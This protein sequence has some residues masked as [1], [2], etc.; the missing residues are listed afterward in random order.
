MSILSSRLKLCKVWRTPCCQLNF[1]T[2]TSSKRPPKKIINGSVRK[3][4][5]NELTLF[6]AAEI[7][8]FHIIGNRQIKKMHAV[9]LPQILLNFS[10]VGV[11]LLDYYYYSAVPVAAVVSLMCHPIIIW[12]GSSKIVDLSF[13]PTKNEVY[14]HSV[15]QVNHT[16]PITHCSLTS[17]QFMADNIRFYFY[18]LGNFNQR[19]LTHFKKKL[20]ILSSEKSGPEF[21][22]DRTIGLV[23]GSYFVYLIGSC[24]VMLALYF[25]TGYS[26]LAYCM[27]LSGDLCEKYFGFNIF[28]NRFSHL[29]LPNKMSVQ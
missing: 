13:D 4:Q 9:L 6:A 15:T 2:S 25:T 22:L 19:N 11:P 8:R 5:R 20:E 28:E 7:S 29:V 14:L 27:K 21:K 3:H 18:N 1:S 17:K 12:T 24:L 23:S 16:I 10:G 26:D